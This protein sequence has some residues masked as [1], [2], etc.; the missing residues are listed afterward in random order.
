MGTDGMFPDFLSCGRKNPEG[1]ATVESHPCAKGRARMG[2]PASFSACADLFLDGAL[3]AGCV[4]K[5][6]LGV[7]SAASFFGAWCARGQTGLQPGAL[8]HLQC[9]LERGVVC[10]S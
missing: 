1:A 6:V 7:A 9:P 10:R 8:H 4:L 5:G 3:G 2:P